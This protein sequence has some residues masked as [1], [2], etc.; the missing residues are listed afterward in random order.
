ILVGGQNDSQNWEIKTINIEPEN[1]VKGKLVD[2]FKYVVE[3]LTEDQAN[4]RLIATHKQG[5]YSPIEKVF[6]LSKNKQGISGKPSENFF[7]LINDTAVKKDKVTNKMEP[8]EL[9]VQGNSIRG[10]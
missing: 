4:V 6:K 10:D 3:E 1:S 7:L 8:E 2:G 9:I 5:K